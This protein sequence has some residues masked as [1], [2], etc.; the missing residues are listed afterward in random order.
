MAYPN[1]SYGDIL[2][3]TIQLLQDDI[4]DQ[5]SNNNA[6]LFELKSRDQIKT[7]DGGP[8]I[9]Q[10][11][12]YAENGTYQRYQGY[13]QLDISPSQVFTAAEYLIK[14]VAISVSMSGLEMI[15]NSGKSQMK[16]LMEARLKNARN[17]LDNNFEVDLW[18]AGTASGGKQIGGLQ[19]LIADLPTSGTVGGISRSSYSWWQ[20]QYYRGVTDGGAAVSTANIQLYM[21]RLLNKLFI[22]K[23]R[24]T[25][26]LSDGTFYNYFWESLVAIQRFQ[27][28]QKNNMASAGFDSVLFESIPVVNCAGLGAACPANHMYFV[29]GKYLYLRPFKGRQFTELNPTR[30]SVNQDAEVRLIAWAGNLTLSNGRKQGVLVA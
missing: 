1:A 21:K 29:N 30:H 12:E 20:N 3:T 28:D 2:S 27:S 23:E 22:A 25:V 5:I 16:D 18:S 24:P 11:L 13:E 4:V 19:S 15:Q 17:T 7:F 26:I 8:K 10:P 9:V 6:L 14:Q